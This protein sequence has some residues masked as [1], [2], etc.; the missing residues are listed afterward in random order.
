[1][2]GAFLHRLAPSQSERLVNARMHSLRSARQP[3][4]WRKSET[5]APVLQ[6]AWTI[7]MDAQRAGMA[8]IRFVRGRQTKNTAEAWLGPRSRVAQST[9]PHKCSR[10]GS[11][12]A[13]T[14]PRKTEESPQGAVLCRRMAASHTSLRRRGMTRF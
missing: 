11:A 14:R 4:F 5:R 7:D 13:L 1:F 8:K 12:Q 6:S 10:Y 2:D 3:G 9:Q